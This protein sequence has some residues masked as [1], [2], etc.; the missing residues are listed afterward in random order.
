M[1]SPNFPVCVVIHG[2]YSTTF[3]RKEL[4][5]MSDQVVNPRYTE[6]FPT[7][8]TPPFLYHYVD[9]SICLEI[10][11]F[12]VHLILRITKFTLLDD[13]V[14]NW[15]YIV[16]PS[17]SVEAWVE[18]SDLYGLFHFSLHHSCSAQCSA[19]FVPI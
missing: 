14:P 18:G 6:Q 5:A 10:T 4:L 2:Q 13:V 17:I 7:L 1:R 16:P 15:W 3:I 12:L 8:P 19:D 11:Q 9:S